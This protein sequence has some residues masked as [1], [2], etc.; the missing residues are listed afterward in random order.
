MEIRC[1]SEIRSR[2]APIVSRCQLD[3]PDRSNVHVSEPF[4]CSMVASS[5]RPRDERPGSPLC[6]LE[7]RSNLRPGGRRAGRMSG[8]GRIPANSTG[9]NLTRTQRMLDAKSAPELGPSVSART[10]LT[11]PASNA[12]Q[13]DSS[14]P[15]LPHLPL[16]RQRPHQPSAASHVRRPCGARDPDWHRS[17]TA[18]S[19]QT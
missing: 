9:A 16:G 11:A 2:R 1:S 19:P 8:L 4:R 18:I 5:P 12:P 10:R 13:R 7:D 14:A 17:F 3:F 15:L 6:P